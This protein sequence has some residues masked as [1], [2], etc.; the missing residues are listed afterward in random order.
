MVTGVF[1][2]IVF[3]LY[4]TQL[5]L[6]YDSG[7]SSGQTLFHFLIPVQLRQQFIYKVVIAAWC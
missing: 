4:T 6:N 7:V 2:R 5:E 3:L 1:W